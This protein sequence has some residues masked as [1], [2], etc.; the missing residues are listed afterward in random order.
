MS[1]T[2]GLDYLNKWNDALNNVTRLDNT[3]RERLRFLAKEYPD[4]VIDNLTKNKAKDILT[5]TYINRIKTTDC[6]DY[7]ILIEIWIDYQHN[8]HKQLNINFKQ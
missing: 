2:K 5:D 6:I 3:I 4:A 1:K 8:K 7:I